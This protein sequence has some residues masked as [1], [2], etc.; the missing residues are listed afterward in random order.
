M[1]WKLLLGVAAAAAVVTVAYVIWKNYAKDIRNYMIRNNIQTRWMV[2]AFAYFDIAM[3]GFEGR[4]VKLL[5]L[6]AKAPG[7]TEEK[8]YLAEETV[9]DPSMLDANLA[10]LVREKQKVYQDLTKE[11]MELSN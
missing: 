8:V 6:V 5:G 2:K 9:V 4:V 10:K 3:K 1:W 7:Q 11:V